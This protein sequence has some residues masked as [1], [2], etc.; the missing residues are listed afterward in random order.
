MKKYIWNSSTYPYVNQIWFTPNDLRS[1]IGAVLPPAT[2]L[3]IAAAAAAPAAVEEE[4]KLWDMPLADCEGTTT[5]AAAI[6]PE[7]FYDNKICKLSY[8]LN[9]KY[10]I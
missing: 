5:S 4:P 8:H 6:V 3:A 7:K 9:C 2:A 10:D 1:V